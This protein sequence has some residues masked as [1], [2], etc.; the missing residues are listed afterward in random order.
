[1][2][3]PA[4]ENGAVFVSATRF[5]YRRLSHMPFVFCH[6][7]L[8]R[9]QW[10]RVDGAIG[11]F[12]GAS[13]PERTTYTV[14]AWTTEADL[15]RWM[16]S[17]YHVRL[18]KDYRGYLESSRAVSW[19]EKAFDPNAAWREALARLDA[20]RATSSAAPAATQPRT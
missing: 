6:G 7:L 9:R 1:M 8:L 17:R 15:H 13:L 20:S 11:M 19:L 16:G 10:D 14:S 12:T 2:R 4:E 18:M 5:T 3:G